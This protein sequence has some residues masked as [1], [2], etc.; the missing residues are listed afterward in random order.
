MFIRFT[1]PAAS[2]TK[3]WFSSC[4]SAMAARILDG[5]LIGLPFVFLD[6]EAFRVISSS[7]ELACVSWKQQ[8]RN[9]LYIR[10]LEV[11]AWVIR[12]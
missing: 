6:L 7:D 9:R 11:V 5:S 12:A 8:E 4:G 2:A 10:R 3:I 1:L